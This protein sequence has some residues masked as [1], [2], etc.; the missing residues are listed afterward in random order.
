MRA[1]Y[2]M[3]LCL[4]LAAPAFAGVEVID[5]DTIKVD[6]ETFDL[7]GIA[8]PEHWQVCP[9]GWPAGAM[10]TEVLRALMRDRKVV[11]EPKGKSR[12]SPNMA[13]CWADGLDVASM[14]VRAGAAWALARSG[15][16]YMRREAEAWAAR[17]GVYAHNCVPAWQRRSGESS[18]GRGG[19]L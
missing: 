1:T 12:Y 18:G 3:L 6:G 13:V 17:A 8:A 11:C 14:M 2:A 16:E 5:G 19:S 4:A 9:D 15:S 7:Y 10:A